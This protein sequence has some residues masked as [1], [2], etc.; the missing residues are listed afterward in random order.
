MAA[1]DIDTRDSVMIVIVNLK[2]N[3]SPNQ[4]SSSSMS[5]TLTT[6]E[7]YYILIEGNIED[8]NLFISK[9]LSSVEGITENEYSA[10]NDPLVPNKF[11]L[12]TQSIKGDIINS[13]VYSNTYENVEDQ[14]KLYLGFSYTGGQKS[15]INTKDINFFMTKTGEKCLTETISNDRL[16]KT[17]N[18]EDISFLSGHPGTIKFDCSNLDL[19]SKEMIEGIV[20]IGVKDSTRGESARAIPNTGELRLRVD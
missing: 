10:A 6:K 15:S 3:E 7:E 17:G 18:S 2:N 16:D 20:T 14:N 1:Y 13:V 9:Y 11:D 5:T 4:I 8:R 12:S 19:I